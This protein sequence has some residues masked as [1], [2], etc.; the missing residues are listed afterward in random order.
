MPSEDQRHGAL[1]VPPM[2]AQDP[3]CGLLFNQQEY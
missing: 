2:R 3:K 1:V